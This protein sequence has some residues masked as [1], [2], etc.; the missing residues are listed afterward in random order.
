MEMA[1]TADPISAERAH[2]LGL[3]THIT[4]PGQTVGA[5]LDIAARIARNG[6]LAVSAT[7]QVIRD[8]SLLPDAQAWQAQEP[9]AARVF[10]SNDAKEGP[11]AFAEKRLPM[12]TG[13]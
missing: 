8:T 4:E 12:W 1:L 2:E 13:T 5:A 10:S 3:V 6:P 11:R 9:F 7:K